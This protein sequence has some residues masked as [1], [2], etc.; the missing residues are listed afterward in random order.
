MQLMVELYYLK[1]IVCVERNT[2][3]GVRNDIIEHT[4]EFMTD[5]G[6]REVKKWFKDF[7]PVFPDENERIEHFTLASVKREPLGIYAGSWFP[8]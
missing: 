3:E 4:L 6:A 7:C 2:P 1:Y 8:D 5:C